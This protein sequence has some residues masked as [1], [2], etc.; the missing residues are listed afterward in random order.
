MDRSAWLLTLLCLCSCLGAKDHALFDDGP[1]GMA[2]GAASAT[3]A[4]SSGAQSGTVSGSSSGSAGSGAS[5]GSVGASGGSSG[6][7]G[8]STEPIAGTQS[9]GGTGPQPPVIV[10]CAMLEGAVT[11]DVN[12]H[13]YRVNES[14]LTFEQARDACRQAGGHLVTISTEA[15]DDFAEA[16]HDGEHWIGASDGRAD[17]MSGVGTYT[18][19]VDEPFDYADWEDGQPNAFETDCPDADGA[20]DCFEHCA[21][22]SDEG[23]WNDR[24]CWHTIVSICEWDIE[25]GGGTL[26]DAGAAS[27]P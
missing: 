4:T 8:S 11:S 12:G 2:S 26:G 13:C 21:F 25:G 3:G 24:S 7:G 17:T 5:A 9:S 1:N 18:W 14:E 20:A 27:Q 19:V 22:Q 6:S 15:E 16:L 23:D 10:D